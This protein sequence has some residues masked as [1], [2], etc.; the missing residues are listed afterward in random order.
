PR[1]RRPGTARERGDLRP[2][3]TDRGGAQPRMSRL[4]S[5]SQ[6]VFAVGVSHHTVPVEVLE[7]LAFSGGAGARVMGEVASHDAIDEVVLLST[8]NRTEL[9]LVVTDCLEAERVALATLCLEAG[10]APTELRLQPL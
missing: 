9:H 5:R 8:C 1:A 6:Q 3:P 4:G 7:R 10:V 2:E